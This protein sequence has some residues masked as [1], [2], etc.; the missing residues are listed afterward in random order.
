M[1]KW[2]KLVFGSL[3]VGLTVPVAC[4][5]DDEKQSP[6]RSQFTSRADA[7][8][9]E[10]RERSR[11]IERRLDRTSDAQK[12]L[13]L[14]R[15]RR[16]Y[17]DE[18]LVRLEDLAAPEADRQTIARYIGTLRKRHELGKRLERA[19]EQ[20][21][22]STARAVLPDAVEL[23]RAAFLAASRLGLEECE[24]GR[25]ASGRDVLDVLTPDVGVPVRLDA[26]AT[27][28]NVT[29]EGVVDPFEVGAGAPPDGARFVAVELEIEISARCRSTSRWR[30]GQPLS[31]ARIIS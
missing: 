14:L 16:T 11:R 12:Q 6:T 13:S 9:K 8:C 22:L 1:G 17:Q 27:T 5:G 18:A 31:P 10:L 3:L 20:E 25:P 19:L 15:E 7:A 30:S 23:N 21:D 4:G 28:L 29:V 24:K 26:G 2:R